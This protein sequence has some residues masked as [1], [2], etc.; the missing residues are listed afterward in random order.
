MNKV[1]LIVFIGFWIY[2]NIE[3][4]GV[5]LLPQV[6]INSM[7]KENYYYRNRKDEQRQ[8]QEK[9]LISFLVGIGHRKDC[10]I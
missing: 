8:I 10:K 6:K 5:N 7:E 4:D 2:V 3:P 1:N 9:S